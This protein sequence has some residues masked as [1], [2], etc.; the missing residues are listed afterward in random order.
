MKNSD[1]SV[2]VGL[3]NRM[4]RTYWKNH[5]AK[6]RSLSGESPNRRGRPNTK[7]AEAPKKLASEKPQSSFSRNNVVL[8]KHPKL[9][10]KFAVALIATNSGNIY[11]ILMLEK[12]RETVCLFLYLFFLIFAFEL[13]ILIGGCFQGKRTIH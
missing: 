7:S 1:E 5:I 4:A 8:I 6:M 2:N 11:T 9:L 3:F 13:F 10:G 12:D